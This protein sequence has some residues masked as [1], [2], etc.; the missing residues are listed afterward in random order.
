MDRRTLID[1]ILEQGKGLPAWVRQALE[2]PGTGDARVLGLFHLRRR[3][4][5]GDMEPIEPAVLIEVERHALSRSRQERRAIVQCYWPEGGRLRVAVREAQGP[6]WSLFA[7]R[8]GG[9]PGLVNGE[10]GQSFPTS[11]TS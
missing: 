7:G 5:D 2:E 10:A 4:A 8:R 3:V 1:Q 11:P 9:L 6:D